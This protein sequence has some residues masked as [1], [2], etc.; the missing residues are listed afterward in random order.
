MKDLR[1]IIRNL[2]MEACKRPEYFGAAGSGGLHPPTHLLPAVGHR[3]VH[4]RKRAQ[5]A[6]S[7]L[8]TFIREAVYTGCVNQ[9]NRSS[10]FSKTPFCHTQE[11]LWHTSNMLSLRPVTV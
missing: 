3:V 4:N 10:Q 1:K 7:A 6:P 11:K 5:N 8:S 9:P 2:V